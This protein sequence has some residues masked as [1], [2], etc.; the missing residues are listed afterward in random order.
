MQIILD[1]L[2]SIFIS[3]AILLIVVFIQLRG[4][5]GAA[6]STINYMVYSEALQ[7]NQLLERD[8]ENM[9]TEDQTLNAVSFTG[10]SGTF[11]C[12]LYTREGRAYSLTFPTIAD[13]DNSIDTIG[14]PNTAAAIEVNYVLDPTGDSVAVDLGNVTQLVPLFTLNRYVGTSL[15]ASSMPYV[16]NF[17]VRFGN[18]GSTS[19]IP[20][21]M[22]TETTTQCGANMTKVRFDFK[23]IADGIEFVSRD[24]RSTGRLNISRFG[25]TISL[26]NW[27]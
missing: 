22:V 11:A 3:A 5:L 7:V 26:S 17:E 14:D 27:E 9:L 21:D 8:L 10:G 18:Q 2:A 24:Q 13:P 23:L 4:S 12:S 6:E 15:T 19:F 1:H 20:T 25:S 16:T